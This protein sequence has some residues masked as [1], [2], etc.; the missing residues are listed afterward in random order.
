MK[1]SEA[2]LAALIVGCCGLVYPA[3]PTAQVDGGDATRSRPYFEENAGQTAAPVRFLSRG[4]KHVLY[5]TQTEAVLVVDANAR[6]KR[7]RERAAR[8]AGVAVDAEA[9]VR[10]AP[11]VLRLRFRNANPSV[12]LVGE[13]RLAGV[14][15]YFLGDDPPEG[16]ARA[17]HF[18]AVRYVALYPGIDALFH[19]S[20][21]NLEYDFIVAPG[22]DPSQVQIEFTGAASLAL[23]ASGDLVARLGHSDITLRRPVAYQMD[24]ARRRDVAARMA[25]DGECSVRFQ[26]GAYDTTKPLIVDPV[27]AFSTYLGG[28][29]SDNAVDVAVDAVGAVYVVGETLSLNFPTLTPFQGE[30]GG[31]GD[32]AGDL[33]VAKI[34]PTRSALVYA[35]YLGGSGD[36]R[37]DGIAV[38][39]TGAAYVT[40]DTES[41]DY[42]TTPGAFQ[43]E[44]RGGSYDGFVT[45]L[46]PS[47]T[48]LVYS[49]YLGGTANDFGRDITVDST[50][51]AYVAG[52]TFS[53]DFPAVNAAQ[54]TFGGR[55]F[56]AFVTKLNPAGSAA[57][58]STYLGGGSYDVAGGI[59]VDDAG[60][61]YVVGF[62]FSTNFPVVQ[63]LQANKSGG[64]DVFVTKVSPTGSSFVY[65]TYLGGSG[66]DYGRS[67]AVDG[68]G[69]CTVVGMTLSTNFPNQSA[70]QSRHGGG[71]FDGFVTRLNA[72]GSGLV[73]STFLGGNDYDEV[74]D[75]VL[76]A[77]GSA[78]LSGA[79]ESANF[80]VASPVQAN[81]RGGDGV[82]LL[83]PTGIVGTGFGFIS[84]TVETD[85]FVGKLGASGS[86]LEFSSYL[87]GTKD[88]FG[89][90]IAID[91][92][93][94]TY[95][96]GESSSTGYPLK[97]PIQDSLAGDLDSVVTV[98]DNSGPDFTM[99]VSPTML[100]LNPKAKS[101]VT[102][103]INRTGS[104][105]GRVTVAADVPAGINV[106]VKP[107]S[108][109]TTGD[110]LTF[111]VKTKKT[112]TVGTHEIVFTGRDDAGREHTTTLT[113]EV[114][115]NRGT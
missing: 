42:P 70:F 36:E 77:D 52:D 93:G 71:E 54:P 90:A 75:V 2:V 53:T 11:E 96:A 92:T 106:K 60:A 98:I 16:G 65:S 17:R 35:T 86:T 43:P 95:L 61:A 18:G 21:A 38:D 6:A 58:Y 84:Y 80:P 24:G 12:A 112:A 10:S 34:D 59:D 28:A 47:G 9:A 102:V 23:T 113:L 88:D 85:A 109:S 15:T 72:T 33:F 115:A 74:F 41:T 103:T 66:D 32:F 108:Q 83:R 89:D 30:F 48:T 14:S 107:G 64:C 91:A 20:G 104:P 26:I 79:T 94:T 45:K 105:Q 49:T 76:G 40:G 73:Y 3:S 8:E 1:Q 87:G 67:I 5:L 69:T 62:T 82:F 29:D 46:A 51:A 78:H 101:S 22:A 68:A 27:I 13:G 100:S 31:A 99:E 81:Y 25:I 111:K 7:V 37:A 110:T 55:I 19:T 44:Y 50:G 4:T 56:D 97:D 57:V 114:V 63:P 39:S